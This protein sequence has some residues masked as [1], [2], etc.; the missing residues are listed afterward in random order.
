MSEFTVEIETVRLR[1][2]PKRIMTL[3]VGESAPASGK[4]FYCGDTA[5]KRYM[6]KAMDA[7]GFGRGG[8]FFECFKAYGWYLDDLVLTPVN[9]LTPSQRKIQ[10]LGA[11][12]SLA[13]RIAQYRPSAIVPILL[14]IKKIV[15]KAAIEAGSTAPHYPVPFPG[16]SHQRRFLSEMA[17]I[18]PKLPKETD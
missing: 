9:M 5:L 6:Q 2:R 10:C 3:F 13:D 11:Q 12:K 17:L 16:N 1:Y 8:D 14:G 15:K 4:F 18:L 7:A